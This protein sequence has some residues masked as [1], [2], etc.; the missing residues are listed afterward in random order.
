MLN[1]DRCNILCLHTKQANTM[2]PLR[3]YDVKFTF[4]QTT[5]DRGSVKSIITFIFPSEELVRAVWMWRCWCA[6]VLPGSA[7][8][9]ATA[10][11][12]QTG[13]Y[14]QR[15]TL[16]SSEI[17]HRKPVI[18]VTQF[19]ALARVTAF[20]ESAFQQNGLR[21]IGVR[22]IGIRRKSTWHSVIRHSANRHWL[23]LPDTSYWSLE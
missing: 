2:D 18:H 3:R 12:T 23:K 20:G 1:A 19:T 17:K 15:K 5:T 16:C 4:F 9:Q 14:V 6:R 22:K 13:I 7:S 10:S 11:W 21:R 8:A